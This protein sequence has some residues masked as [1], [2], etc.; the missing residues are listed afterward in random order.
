MLNSIK[1]NLSSIFIKNL[2]ASAFVVLTPLVVAEGPSDGPAHSHL[3][4]RQVL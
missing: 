2:A 4:V 3:S 1:L